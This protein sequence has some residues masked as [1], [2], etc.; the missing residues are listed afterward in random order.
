MNVLKITRLSSIRF[1]YHRFEGKIFEKAPLK[2]PIA[3]QLLRLQL[4]HNYEKFEPYRK[5]YLKYLGH[6]NVDSINDL[7]RH[8]DTGQVALLI[9]V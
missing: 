4:P 8:E 9:Q 6:N 7:D 3:Q 5:E 2:I 1:H